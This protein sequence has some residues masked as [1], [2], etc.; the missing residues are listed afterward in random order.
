MKYTID[1][2]TLAFSGKGVKPLFKSLNKV[3]QEQGTD[4][5]VVGAFAR[6]LILH[7]IFDRPA[8]ILTKDI[9]VGILLPNWSGFKQLTET[10]T[11]KHGFSRGRLPYLFISPDGLPTDLLPF[12]GVED[13]RGISFSETDHLRMNMMG[14]AEAWQTRLTISL[15]QEQEF[16]IPTPEGLIL[17]K[18]IAW[19][20]RTPNLVA[21]KHITDIS[22]II[23]DYF[24]ANADDLDQDPDFAD[25]YDLSGD[26]FN[27]KWYA[28]VAIGRIIQRM[29]SAYP[30]T[31]QTL[32]DIFD[33][34]LDQKTGEFFQQRMASVLREDETVVIGV[35][36]RLRNEL[37]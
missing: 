31:R 27:M 26:T 32:L 22:R 4:F 7:N 10:L 19:N 8:G 20:D 29:V 6:D 2:K 18:L 13:Q 9:D 11:N 24:E 15:D 3:C 5:L 21:L 25:L 33:K 30:E 35:I 12:G 37:A 1:S 14:F 34:A 28:A 23:D 16:N 17:L 36:E